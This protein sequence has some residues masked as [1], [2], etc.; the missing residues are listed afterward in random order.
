MRRTRAT[1]QLTELELAPFDL[2]ETGELVRL[3]TGREPSADDVAGPRLGDRRLPAVR[4]GGDP[5]RRPAV[6]GEEVATDLDAMLRARFEQLGP[7]GPAGGGAGGRHRP[8]LRP[9]PALRG[10]RPRPGRG[11][12]GGRRALAA[13]HPH[14]AP[15]RLRLLPRA[16][17]DHGVPP[18]HPRRPVAAAPPAGAGR[19][20]SCT[21]AAPTR[22]PPSW[23]TSTP[24]PATPLRALEQYHRAAEVAARVFAHAEAIRLH[25]AALAP[26]RRAPARRR[27]RPARGPHADRDDGRAQRAPGLLRPRAGDR[28][29]AH[30]RP[31]RAALRAHRARWTPSSGSGPRGSSGATSCAPTSWPRGRWPWPPPAPTTGALRGQAH[32]AFAGSALSLGMPATAGGALRAGLR[33]VLRRAVAEHREPPGHPRPGLVRPRPLAAGRAR[34]RRRPARPRRSSGPA[35]ASTR[36]ASRSRSGYAARDLAAARRARAPGRRA[37]TSSARS[38]PATASPT[39]PSGGWSSAAGRATTRPAP[40]EME[41][42]H[43]APARGRRVRPDAVLAEPAGRARPTPD[44]ARA[45]PRQRPGLGAGPRRPV[46]APGGAAAARRPRSGPRRGRPPGCATRSRSPRSRAASRSPNAA[47]ATSAR[48]RTPGERSP[49]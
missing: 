35:P 12:P 9:R 42:G 27:P 43:R 25:R 39:T 6:P 21:P 20:R 33:A 4:R 45:A 10:L 44:R 15:H 22:W 38:A 24:A 1:G 8:R 7:V 2:D 41:H 37:S 30:D 5:A 18:G 3:L 13:A 26:A 47:V 31:G 16:A 28:A 11:G 40:R 32:F 48:T 36:T 17:A 19:W 49:S 23:P 34:P 29:G 46:V 14:R